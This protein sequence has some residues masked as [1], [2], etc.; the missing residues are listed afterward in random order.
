MAQVIQRA[1]R[2]IAQLV[3][4]LASL[5]GHVDPLRLAAHGLGNAVAV[6]AGAGKLFVSGNFEQR[7]PVVGRIHLRRQQ[8]VF[9]REGFQ[10]DA[11]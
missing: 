4:E 9:R 7:I 8:R 10:G 1:G 6:R 3:A 5:L 11:G 2:L